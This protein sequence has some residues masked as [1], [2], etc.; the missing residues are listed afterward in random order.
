M[1]NY[2]HTVKNRTLISSISMSMQLKAGEDKDNGNQSRTESFLLSLHTILH[3]FVATKATPR[4]NRHGNNKGRYR[5]AL[6]S[7]PPPS[8]EGI[9]LT[10][11]N[12]RRP[13]E[14]YE[15]CT[16]GPSFSLWDYLSVT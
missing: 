5:D 9:C 3:V 2:C 10:P 7:I 14:D 1:S 11:S 4:G 16:S 13:G 6:L 15:R 8:E 12:H